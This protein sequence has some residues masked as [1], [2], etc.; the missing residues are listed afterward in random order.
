MIGA[1]KTHIV[2][3]ANLNNKRINSYLEFCEQMKMLNK[4]PNGGNIIYHTT[5]EGEK[6]LRS[7]FGT[8]RGRKFAKN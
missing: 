1:N 3:V 6:F 7:Y 4:S 8:L 2:S 5:S